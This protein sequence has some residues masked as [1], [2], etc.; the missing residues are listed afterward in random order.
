MSQNLFDRPDYKGQFRA[1]TRDEFKAFLA[2]IRHYWIL[3]C[4]IIVGI[5]LLL[6]QSN[7]FPP[8]TVTIATGQALSSADRLGE[9]YK[10]FFAANGVD[11]V[12]VPSDGAEDNLK[13]LQDGTVQ[14]AFTQAG[15]PAA[16]GS[17]LLSLGS[18]EFQPVWLFYRGKPVDQNW[19]AQ[20]MSKWQIAVGLQSSGTYFMVRDL[21]KEYGL[22]PETYSN[23]LQIPTNE[24][25]DKLING[26]ID[27]LFILGGTESQNLQR[28]LHADNLQNWN[29]RA[30]K[31]TA[32]RIQ[33]A[34][35]VVFPRGAVSLSPLVPEQDIEL[36]A[37]SAT[38]TVQPDLHPAIQYLFMA[39]TES[40]YKNTENY[41]SRP[42]GFPAFL[43]QNFK[44]SPVAVKYIDNPGSTLKHDM[45]FWVA[46]LI[47]RAWLWM[48]AILAVFLPLMKLIPQYRKYHA[49]LVQ[50][51]HYAAMNDLVHKV[52]AAES[53]TE[54]SVH[55][56]KFQA[57]VDTIENTW[58]P[59]GTKEKYFF[60]LNA[61]ETMRR[62][63]ERKRESLEDA[64]SVGLNQR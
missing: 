29:F 58:A 3:S 47:D 30:A 2:F 41:F 51:A 53:I 22:N 4:L 42:G 17:K 9:W 25:V 56:M 26:E 63:I 57:L 16:K 37:T 15:I 11:L 34:D 21:L 23:L 32:G 7:P 24:S 28:L 14:A 62:H 61:L 10:D 39:A 49:Y 12:L 54:L 44:K 46:S 43:D 27:A 50:N 55:E 6:V 13:R 19:A 52:R 5:V 48:A 18:I 1:H 45:P 31:A 64:E 59:A 36:V 40:H 20:L 38:I 60:M 33:Y 35:A 8:R